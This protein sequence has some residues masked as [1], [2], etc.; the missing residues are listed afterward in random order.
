METHN[1]IFSWLE[2]CHKK[3]QILRLSKREEACLEEEAAETDH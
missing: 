2:K 1:G 3:V